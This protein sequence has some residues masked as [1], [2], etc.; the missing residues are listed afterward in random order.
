VNRISHLLR[1]FHCCFRL[2]FNARLFSFQGFFCGIHLFF[3][4]AFC[5]GFRAFR[6][7]RGLL[8]FF[9]LFLGDVNA[10][11]FALLALRGCFGGNLRRSLRD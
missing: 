10:G 1:D 3:F 6:A 11:P 9:N 4:L 7:L 5:S 2:G 8:T